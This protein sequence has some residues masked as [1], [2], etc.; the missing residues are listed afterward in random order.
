MTTRVVTFG[1]VMGRIA[2]SGFVR[3]TQ[4]LPGSM[5]FTYGG[6]EANVA[7]SL[8]LLG[9]PATFVTALPA[10]PIA[11]AGVM[12]LRGLGV[13]TE[14]IVRTKG[15]RLGLY[16]LEHGANQRASNVVYDRD[17]SSVMITPPEA[18]DWPAIFQGAG[19]FHVTGI[20]PALSE[21]AARAT[22]VAVQAAKEAGV[23][24]SCD[25]NFRKKLWTWK[26]GTESRD[27]AEETMRQVMPFVDV[28]IA[29]E[30]DAEQVLGIH[31]AGTDVEAGALNVEAYQTVAALIVSQFPNVSRVAIT[32]RESISA[33]HNNWGGMLYDATSQAAFFAPMDAAG[34]YRPFEIRDI[35]D[36]VGG[37]DSFAAG[38]IFASITPALSA[39]GDIIRFAVAA[40]CLK[41]S[42]LGDFN[43]ATRPE[44]EALMKGQASGRVNR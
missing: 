2:P 28:V 30:E 5:E 4:A 9:A 14:R 13:D 41:H 15:G 27:L 23:T 1:E 21:N 32:L 3:F 40:S 35:V 6:G 20:T 34:H 19:W 24:V 31:A 22:L 37:G 12:T 33:T 18:Y 39:P 17:G 26:P 29:N 43:Y 44:V 38:L 25:L 7:V 10:N 36:R 42:I 8:S 11:D 16:F